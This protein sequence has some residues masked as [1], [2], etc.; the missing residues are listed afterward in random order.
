MP[1]F[2]EV[3]PAYPHSLPLLRYMEDYFFWPARL[4]MDKGF[5]VEFLTTQKGADK[6]L[7]N[8]VVVRRFGSAFSVLSY[9]NKDKE[10]RLVHS[11]LRPYPPTFLSSFSNKPKILSPHTYLF[12]PNPLIAG[13]SV[14]VMKKFDKIIAFTS[15]ERDIYLRA[16]IEGKKIVIIPHPVDHE[17][18]SASVKNKGAIRE[19][20]GIN[21]EFVV[22]TV[23]NVRKFKRIETLLRAFKIVS[24]KIKS[25]L[26]VVGEDLLWKEKAPSVS[27]MVK[28]IGVKGVIQAGVLMPE[29]VREILAIADVFVNTSDN[30]AQGLAVYEAAA[31]GIPLCLSGIGSFTSVFGSL[32]HYHDYW[33][34][35]KLADNLLYCHSNRR[36]SV[37]RGRKLKAFVRA[38]DF[39]ALRKKT[40][41]LYEEI[42][43]R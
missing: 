32:A 30:E 19:K 27:D 5:D 22:V 35:E 31:A 2:I 9:I 39:T 20:L 10:T 1:K 6:E 43:R 13:L 40:E 42:M 17:F 11:H 24:S 21:G 29:K 28:Q 36:E 18:Y 7:C 26:I 38:W 14:M 15:Y 34:H 8:G 3:V 4:M 41:S 33:N 23:A 16:G 37:E 12:S 25:K